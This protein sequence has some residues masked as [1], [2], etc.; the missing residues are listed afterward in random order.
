[1]LV[2]M[3]HIAHVKGDCERIPYVEIHPAPIRLQRE[4]TLDLQRNLLYHV[5]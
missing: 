2:P 1:M 5:K 4:Q 3:V